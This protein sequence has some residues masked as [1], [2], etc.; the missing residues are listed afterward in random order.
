MM[1][2]D[3]LGDNSHKGIF[4]KNIFDLNIERCGINPFLLLNLI[5]IRFVFNEVNM[6]RTDVV[7]TGYN[8]NDDNG[9]GEIKMKCH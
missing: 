6:I 4:S 3:K 8:Y 5:E 7:M 1:V 2:G 9:P